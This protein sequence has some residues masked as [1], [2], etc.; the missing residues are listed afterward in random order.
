MTENE[1]QGM[2]V[3]L[4]QRVEISKCFAELDEYKAIGTIEEFKA[5]KECFGH[6]VPKSRDKAIYDKAIDEFA[7]KMKEICKGITFAELF[8]DEI[9]EGLKGGGADA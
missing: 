6:T 5:L 2:F 8:I 9:A 1:R 3:T 4:E 7:E